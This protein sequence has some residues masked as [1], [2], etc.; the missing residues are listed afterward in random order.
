[1]NLGRLKGKCSRWVADF[2]RILPAPW[3]GDLPVASCPAIQL[4]EVVNRQLTGK[5][6]TVRQPPSYLD[7]PLQ[8]IFESMRS[9]CI[10]ARS[11]IQLN[12]AIYWG[13]AYGCVTTPD[14]V[15]VRDYSPDFKDFDGDDGF[16]RHSILDRPWLPRIETTSSSALA[17]NTF[18]HRNFHHWLLD[19]LT[20]FSILQD[21][22]IEAS[23]LDYLLLQGRPQG[24]QAQCLE[25]LGIP[26]EK[27]IY[28]DS[29]RRLQFD[30]LTVTSFS[31][32][33][34]QPELYDYT[35]EGLNFV[36]NLFLVQPIPSP[37]RSKR[38]VVS[39]R[40]ATARRWIQGDAQRESL[41]T[42]GFQEVML[43]DF[44]VAQQASLFA[45]AETIVMPTGGNLANLI[46]CRPGTRI[47]E[48]FHPGYL[49]AFS[50]TLATSLGLDYIGLVESMDCQVES[51][52]QGKWADIRIAL[53]RVLEF[54]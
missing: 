7:Q 2:R 52:D 4:P 6:I 15:L 40:K 39:R 45:Q 29:R 30:H 50:L 24:F 34:R 38:I 31:E 48:L 5:R 37:V 35:P 53:E 28:T 46:F 22:G 26:Q 14:G 12:K 23:S 32:P 43:E 36:R 51:S 9:G 8:A 3:N 33:G 54:V 21:A 49:P 16:A 42:K 27:V 18:G 10:K 20:A 17:L 41:Q 25:K 1:M 13:G 44:S 19:S 47:I 11:W